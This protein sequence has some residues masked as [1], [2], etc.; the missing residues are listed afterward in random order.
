M[1][2]LEEVVSK[3]MNKKQQMH[4]TQLGAHLLCYRPEHE[5]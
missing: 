1:V 4:W 5:C 3:Q 2:G